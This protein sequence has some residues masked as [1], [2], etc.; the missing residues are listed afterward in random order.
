MDNIGARRGENGTKTGKYELVPRIYD[1]N[2]DPGDTVVIDLYITGYGRIDN[3]KLAFYPPIAIL[4]DSG[5][6][7]TYGFAYQNE[8][9]EWGGH[10]DAVSE[11]GITLPTQGTR[12]DRWPG[13]TSFFDVDEDDTPRIAT[14]TS[15][16]KN[17]SSPYTLK[18]QLSAKAKP[19]NYTT[20]LVFTYFNGETWQTSSVESKF[21]VR[22]VFQRNER[23]ISILGV[24]AAIG[25]IPPIFRVALD[26]WEWLSK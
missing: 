21:T 12:D 24:L 6:A 20:T 16:G 9:V 10:T 25:S 26:V 17:G 7:V 3:S 15:Q 8:Q 22:N 4:S 1:A 18:L 2:I 19:G 14:E 11:R 13:Y 5:S 23:V